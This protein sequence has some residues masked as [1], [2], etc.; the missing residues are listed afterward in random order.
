LAIRKTDYDPDAGVI[1]LVETKDNRERFIP[2]AG[3]TNERLKHCTRQL[4]ARFEGYS[5]TEYLLP[6]AY[7]K[8]YSK[9]T[10]YAFFRE[11]LWQAG[12]S[13]GGR[14]RGPRL[15][16]LRHTYAVMVLNRGFCEGKEMGALLQ[17]LSIYMG[18]TGLKSSERYLRMT[19]EM[20]SKVT[21]CYTETFGW[22]LE[23]GRCHEGE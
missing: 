22:V 17:G 1:R 23:G 10:L 7:G 6:N 21:G 3:S 20:H 14:G 15:H 2:I 16:D 11:M 9:I 5:F 4:A 19:K 18:H 8:P 12:I 13:H